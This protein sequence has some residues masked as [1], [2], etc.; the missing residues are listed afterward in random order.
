MD[1]HFWTSGFIWHSSAELFASE[2]SLVD[3]HFWTSGFIWHSSAELFASV[4]QLTIKSSAILSSIGI[5]LYAHV[6][7]RSLILSLRIASNNANSVLDSQRFWVSA[8]GGGG[9]GRGG[10]G[11]VNKKNF[12]ARENRMKPLETT[13]KII[14]SRYQTFV[15]SLPW[16]YVFLQR[17]PKTEIITGLATQANIFLRWML[18]KG[19]LRLKMPYDIWSC[20]GHLD[21]LKD[22]QFGQWLMRHVI[23][24][25]VPWAENRCLSSNVIALVLR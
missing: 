22:K 20:G 6:L 7:H 1:V 15:S 17:R 3:V 10:R 14:V 18:F 5:I 4:Q 19:A 13:C 11:G 8:G 2:L 9:G 12:R 21:Y 25:Q 23:F 24:F 16:V